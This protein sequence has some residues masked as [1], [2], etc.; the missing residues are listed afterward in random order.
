MTKEVPNISHTQTFLSGATALAIAMGTMHPLDT[1]RTCIQKNIKP[2]NLSRGI[3]TSATAAWPQG[4]IRFMVYEK[5]KKDNMIKTGL[6]KPTITGITYAAVIADLC[7]SIVK[8][9]REV[10]TTNMQINGTNFG[11]TVRH[12]LKVKG[13]LGFFTGTVSTSLRDSPFMVLLFISYELLQSQLEDVFYKTHEKHHIWINAL[14]G[15]TAGGIAGGLT[16]PFDV[17]RTNA[18]ISLTSTGKTTSNLYREGGVKIF[19][20]GFAARSIW[21]MG[22]CGVFFP[23]YEKFKY[24]YIIDENK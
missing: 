11:D 19:F 8:V 1:I 20:R 7:S 21:W 6:E 5:L 18:M 10:V 12:V 2:Q 13:P 9:P 23:L 3:V 15:S 24:Y 16:T 17:I 4:G 14:I 22:V